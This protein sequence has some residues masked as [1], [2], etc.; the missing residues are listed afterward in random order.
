LLGAVGELRILMTP[1]FIAAHRRCL[2]R[3]TT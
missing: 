3:R 2:D 1:N